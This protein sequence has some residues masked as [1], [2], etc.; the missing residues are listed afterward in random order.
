MAEE[1][2][3][4]GSDNPGGPNRNPRR[5][6]KS[7]QELYDDIAVAAGITRQATKKV[8]DSLHACA[9]KSLSEK[10]KFRVPGLVLLTMKTLKERPA[11]VRHVCGK[12]L[13]LRAKPERR[14]VAST[15]LKRFESL[16]VSA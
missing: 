5:S 9:L 12:D 14:K 15:A 4:D 7:E 3:D 11:T 10:G 6:T 1:T 13:P 16:A 8:F 2:Y